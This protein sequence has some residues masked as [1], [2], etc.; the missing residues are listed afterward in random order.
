[1]IFEAIVANIDAT[2]GRFNPKKQRSS[3][4]PA[5]T[6]VAALLL[7]IIDLFHTTTKYML[8]MKGSTPESWGM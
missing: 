3:S 2:G 7:N 8:C 4:E 6:R 1:M 5:Q